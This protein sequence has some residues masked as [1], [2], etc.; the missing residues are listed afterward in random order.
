MR[1][2]YVCYWDL[3][4]HDGVAK[5]IAAQTAAWA[6]HGHTVEV[7]SVSPRDPRLAATRDAARRVA[8]FR[9]DV[10]YVRYDLF[11]PPL[12]RALRRF[13]TVVE[14]NSDDRVEA[15]RWR[16]RAARAYNE[17][18]RRVLLGGASGLVYVTEELAASPSF[19]RFR[20]PRA[21]VSNGIE[22]GEE[23]PPPPA[24]ARP[25]LLFLGTAGQPW[26]GVDKLLAAAARLPQIDI[27]VVGYTSEQLG[28]SIPENVSAHG[29][30]T[31]TEYA[32]LF[33]SAVAG[34]GTLALHRKEM[35]QAAPLKVREYLAA[36]LPVLI[37]YDD[38]D[39]RGV[40]AW[41]LLRFANAEGN[42]DP[43]R[44]GSFVEQVRGRRVPRAEV[45]PRIGREAKERER[46]AFLAT[47]AAA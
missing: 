8:A 7:L 38:V 26:H 18:N 46:L 1:I 47:V 21:F 27:D 2:A 3:E 12:W 35:D 9:P 14:V 45:A 24:G 30:L 28:G 13:R 39:L 4:S 19:S 10:V 40:D 16:G 22:V 6:A 23:S 15:R 11:L 20:A 32:P 17:L 25:R 29:R 33:R 34:V 44:I 5:K 36:G 41:W 42:V 37:A 43:A 31:E